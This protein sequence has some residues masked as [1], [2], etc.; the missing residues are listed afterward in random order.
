V[1]EED[2]PWLLV[3]AEE[4]LDRC[5]EGAGALVVAL[6]GEIENRVIDRAEEPRPDAAIGRVPL[7]VVEVRRRRPIDVR[8]E[9]ELTAHR[10]EEGCPL[11]VVG[12]LHLQGHRNVGLDGDGG[13][14]VDDQRRRGGVIGG[15][16]AAV[17]GG[18]HAA[19][20]GGKRAARARRTARW[21]GCVVQEHKMQI[22]MERLKATEKEG[23]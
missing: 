9:T 3:G 7:G 20:P 8:L 13:V 18:R 14:G 22:R 4:A 11:G 1:R 19:V 2:S 16:H 10:F 23:V 12:V 5:S 17:L 15:R 6:H 21:G